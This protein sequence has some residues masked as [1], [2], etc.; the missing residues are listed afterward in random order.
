VRYTSA[1]ETEAH[2]EQTI[3]PPIPGRR[4]CLDLRLLTWEG[5]RAINVLV[6]YVPGGA[7]PLVIRVALNHEVNGWRGGSGETAN[8]SGK[9]VETQTAQ[10]GS[11]EVIGYPELRWRG[12][13]INL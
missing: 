1:A 2:G 10:E 7:E 3:H 11:P 5:S 4:G 13:N 8:K 12:I 9:H 6:R